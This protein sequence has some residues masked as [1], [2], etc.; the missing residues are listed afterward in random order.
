MASHDARVEEEIRRMEK[1]FHLTETESTRVVVSPRVWQSDRGKSNLILVAQ[2]LSGK[3]LNF[4]AFRD[5]LIGSFKPRR[6][7]EIFRIDHYR[8]LFEFNHVVDMNRVLDNCPWNFDNE[9]LLMKPLPDNEDPLLTRMDWA[10]FFIRVQGLPISKINHTFA[11]IIGNNIGQFMEFD[12]EKSGARWGASMRIRARINI[13]KPLRRVLI[14]SN[15]DG[16]E[17]ELVFTYEKLPNFCYLCGIIGHISDYYELRYDEHFVDPGKKTPYGSWLRAAPRRGS[18]QL[19]TLNSPI[20]T[21]QHSGSYYRVRG[22]D[23]WGANGVTRND[24]EVF[25]TPISSPPRNPPSGLVRQP[26]RP[27]ALREPSVPVRRDLSLHF[28]DESEGESDVN[29]GEDLDSGFPPSN[30]FV[31]GLYISPGRRA[32]TPNPSPI[33]PVTHISSTHHVTTTISSPIPNLSE[34]IAE[35]ASLAPAV[36][37]STTK[38]QPLTIRPIPSH[39]TNLSTI[40]TVIQSPQP[41]MVPIQQHNDLNITH[42]LSPH[43]NQPFTA[44][45][46]SPLS[47]PILINIP[48]HISTTPPRSHKSL[49]VTRKI[50]KAY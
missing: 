31:S 36:L 40:L 28:R 11:K 46:S 22:S 16:D 10:D 20:G 17:F 30:S 45:I 35:R 8:F 41:S 32:T 34:T 12:L 38:S 29:A 37:V 23:I 49:P 33:P 4:P 15:P 39:T 13:S 27:P 3:R 7:M 50:T 5:T 44:P 18:G 42:P 2:L 48:I 6:G 25:R 9:L 24:P 1:A 43:L 14:L 26:Y 19:P 21:P 47:S